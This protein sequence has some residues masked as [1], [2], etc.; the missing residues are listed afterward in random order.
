[1]TQ[2]RQIVRALL[3]VTLAT[4][5][6]LVSSLVLTRLRPSLRIWPPPSRPARQFYFTWVGFWVHPSGAFLLAILDWNSLAV[7]GWIRF[8]LGIPL[9]VLGQILI[10]RAFRALTLHA[11]LGLGGP[12]VRSGPP[13][14][15]RRAAAG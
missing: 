10:S 14:A 12:F 6:L 4:Q 11:T 7:S 3:V 8:G 2:G 5:A 13:R 1:M 9:I 15:P